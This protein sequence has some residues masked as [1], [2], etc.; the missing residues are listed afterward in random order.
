MLPT[1][2]SRSENHRLHVLSSQR[3][4]EVDSIILLFYVLKVSE[5]K[6]KEVVLFKTAQP[7]RETDGIQTQGPLNL[8]TMFFL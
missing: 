4:H 2:A 1:Q 6:G 7:L 5:L 3:P 8:N